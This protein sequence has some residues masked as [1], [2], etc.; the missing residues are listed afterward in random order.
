MMTAEIIQGSEFAAYAGLL[1]GRLRLQHEA[2]LAGPD[3]AVP[4][5]QQIS[6]VDEE[7]AILESN[8][9]LVDSALRHGAILVEGVRAL[10][11]WLEDEQKLADR[12]RRL[13][14][15]AAFLTEQGVE[16]DRLT[17]VQETI[18]LLG[19]IAAQREAE[20]YG[21]ENV[22]PLEV[23]EPESALQYLRA[24]FEDLAPGQQY[25]LT[26]QEILDAVAPNA[27]MSRWQ[28]YRFVQRA[29]K[30]MQA[31]GYIFDHNGKLGR[32]SAYTVGKGEVAPYHQPMSVAA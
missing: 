27:Y 24:Q 22:P 1:E 6:E 3:E 16:D 23:F 10:P 21:G 5:F 19:A 17:Q 12:R 20:V 31:Q 14:Q 26:A 7:I 13:R 18:G 2:R 25:A 29:R 28:R 4:V 11:D 9:H 15:V 8:P 32:A 30:L